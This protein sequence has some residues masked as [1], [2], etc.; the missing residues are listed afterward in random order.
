MVRTA[1]GDYGKFTNLILKDLIKLIDVN[2]FVYSCSICD[3]VQRALLKRKYISADDVCN[4]RGRA[5][6]RMKQIKKMVMQS[7]HSN[8]M[9]LWL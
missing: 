9:K 3:L 5:K 8:I 1:A 2:H 7:T 6:M 4:A